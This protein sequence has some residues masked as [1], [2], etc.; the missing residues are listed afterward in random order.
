MVA[1][2]KM[3]EVWVEVELHG[4]GGEGGGRGRLNHGCG[5]SIKCASGGGVV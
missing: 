3:E 1:G 5:G 4:V 2:A